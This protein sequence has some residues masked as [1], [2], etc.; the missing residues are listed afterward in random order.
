[1]EDFYVEKKFGRE[2]FQQCVQKVLGIFAPY[3]IFIFH[4]VKPRYSAIEGAEKNSH[5][6]EVNFEGFLVEG[7]KHFSHYIEL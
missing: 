6:I 7:T 1:M 4:T 2:K 5:K 3:V